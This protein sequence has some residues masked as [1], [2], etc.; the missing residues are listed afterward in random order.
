MECAVWPVANSFSVRRL[1]SPLLE[2]L[3]AVSIVIGLY[4]LSGIELYAE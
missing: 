3:A 4:L 2:G 1:T